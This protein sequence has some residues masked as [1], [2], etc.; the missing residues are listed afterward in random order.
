MAPREAMALMTHSDLRLTM[1]VYTDPRVFDLAG[2]VEKLPI[3][4]NAAVGMATEHATGTD[5]QGMPYQEPSGGRVADRVA[6]A[7]L[8]RRLRASSGKSAS[9]STR[10]Q[11]QRPAGIGNKKTHPTRWAEKA[12]DGIRTHDVSLGKAAFYH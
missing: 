3:A 2:A 4:L 12:G 6:T 1:K 10:S 7:T 8:D 9:I 11:V 5:A